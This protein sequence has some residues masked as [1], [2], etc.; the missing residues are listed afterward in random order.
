MPE[1][2]QEVDIESQLRRMRGCLGCFV[3]FVLIAGGALAVAII[4]SV[5]A[6]GPEPDWVSVVGVVGSLAL[7]IGLIAVGV[8]IREYWATR[9]TKWLQERQAARGLG[10][11]KPTPV[12]LQTEPSVGPK[13]A[14]AEPV[15]GD[16]RSWPEPP[17]A[18][19]TVDALVEFPPIEIA[20]VSDYLS[21]RFESWHRLSKVGGPL[22]ALGVLIVLVSFIVALSAPI[23]D[24]TERPLVM[25]LGL[26]AGLAVGG[27]GYLLL[28]HVSAGALS[29]CGWLSGL[30]AI[31]WFIGMAAIENYIH[32]VI[33]LVVLGGLSGSLL[34]GGRWLRRVR[35]LAPGEQTAAV[36]ERLRGALERDA[37]MGQAP[38]LIRLRVEGLWRWTGRL[39]RDTILL[40]AKGNFLAGRAMLV[41]RRGDVEVTDCDQQR[42]EAGE[43]RPMRATVLVGG[44]RLKAKAA[45]DDLRRLVH[46]IKATPQPRPTEA[47][48][49]GAQRR[50]FDEGRP[51]C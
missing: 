11:V 14:S 1:E 6:T 43:T 2:P 15:D 17:P 24:D 22:L 32:A 18:V 8:G 25:A 3:V 23:R 49:D 19:E 28:H 45:A 5:N 46:W 41:A 36:L 16:L 21:A 20:G 10:K 40:A 9:R 50:L 44:A 35:H 38:D 4:A 48:P 12:P 34:S 51:Q 47:A 37:D 31:A 26:A 29:V 30:L 39:Y 33:G 42:L 7:V 13:T 27:L